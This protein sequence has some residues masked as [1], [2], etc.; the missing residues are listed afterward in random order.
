[1]ARVRWGIGFL[2]PKWGLWFVGLANRLQ[3]DKPV[4]ETGS[5]TVQ[6][7]LETSSSRVST[8][9]KGH[10]IPYLC[11]HSISVAVKLNWPGGIEVNR[12]RDR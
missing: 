2:C 8:E 3:L 9:T 6:R 10:G 4:C 11:Y 7:I 12:V 5:N 1:M